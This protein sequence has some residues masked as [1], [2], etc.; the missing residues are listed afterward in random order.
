MAKF[1]KARFI[2]GNDLGGL[3]MDVGLEFH[4]TIDYDR[5]KMR[6]AL[7]TGGRDVIKEARRLVSRR[8]I[9]SPGGIPGELT[10]AL[11]RSI[12]TLTKGSKGGWIKVGPKRTKEMEAKAAKPEWAFYPAFLFYG[13]PATGLAKRAN[14]MEAALQ[15]KREAVRSKVRAALKDSL[16]PR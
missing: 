5:K 3:R 1:N 15:N 12:S 14:F 6:K 16:V 2:S 9:S 8:A 7:V 11:K 4:K 13:S 10:G